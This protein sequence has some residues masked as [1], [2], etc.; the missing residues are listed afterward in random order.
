MRRQASRSRCATSAPTPVQGSSPRC[1]ATSCRCPGWARPRP[2]STSTWTRTG[3][4]SDSSSDAADPYLSRTVGGFLD[5]LAERTPAPGGGA[6][7]ALT[8]AMGAALVEMATSFASA[9][10]LERVRERAHEI[11][12]EVSHLAHADGVAYAHVLE[13]L[14]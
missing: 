1:A 8:C 4:L 7:A 12:L 3:R 9:H 5:D 6:A 10:G 2:G 13:A 11:R 14:R